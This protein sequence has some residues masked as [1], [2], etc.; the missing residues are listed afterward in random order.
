MNT[1]VTRKILL[2]ISGGLLGVCSIAMAQVEPVREYY[3][4]I[5]EQHIRDWSDAISPNANN[6]GTSEQVRSFTSL[7]FS[8]DA[9]VVYYDHWED[10]YEADIINPVQA[11]TEVWG[12]ANASNG[13]RPGCAV[14]SCDRIAAADLIVLDN[15]VQL[16]R[17]SASRYYD[18]RDY[19]ASTG[20]VVVSRHGYRL[21]EGSLL[22]GASEVFPLASWGTSFEAPV[23]ENISAHD[24]FSYSAVSII[25]SADSTTVNID[26]DGDGSADVTQVLDRG[27]SLFDGDLST[28][29]NGMLSGGTITATNPIQ[30]YLLTGDRDTTYAGRWYTLIPSE[31]WSDEYYTP[32]GS[33]DPDPSDDEQATFVTFYNPGASSITV[34]HETRSGGTVNSGTVS[35]PAGGQTDLRMPEDSGG[36]FYTVGNETFY[37]LATVDYDS[38]ATDWGFPLIPS[39]QLTTGVVVGLGWGQVNPAAPP[40]EN[41]SPV[42]VTAVADTTLFIDYDS[43]PTTGSLIDANGD[44]YDAQVA[45][46]EL[47][48]L[49]IRDTSDGDQ[50]QLRIYTLDGTLI[51]AAWGQDPATAS[52]AAP[53]LDMGTFVIPFPDIDVTKEGVLIFDVDGDGAMDPGDTIQYTILVINNG[54]SANEAVLEDTLD[55]NTTYVPNTVEIDGV[56]IADDALPDTAFPLDVDGTN[57]GYNLGVLDPLQVVTIVFQV[58]INN[59]LPPGVEGLV[60]HVRV[61]ASEEVVADTALSVLGDPGITISKVSDAAGPLSPGDVVT[62]TITVNNTSASAAT[63]IEV[64]DIVPSNATYVA[65]STEVLAPANQE[66]WRDEFDASSYSNNDGTQNWASDWIETDPNG[67]DV[68]GPGTQSGQVLTIF[69]FSPDCNG[70]QC[71]AITAD[72]SGGAVDITGMAFSRSADLT[73]AVT[74]TLS[75]THSYYGLYGGPHGSLELQVRDS[76]GSGWTTL[77]T[78][79]YGVTNSFDNFESYDISAHI[80]ATTEIRLLGSGNATG[81]KSFDDIQITGQFYDTFSNAAGA[82]NALLDGNPQNLVRPADGLDL[83]GGLSM[84]VTYEATVDGPPAPGNAQVINT[85]I[86]S[87]NEV[88]QPQYAVVAD[89]LHSGVVSGRVWV[90]AD[91]DGFEDIVEPGIG[92]V[93]VSLVDPVDGIIGNGND[94]VLYTQDTDANGEY[95]FYYLEAGDYY[96]DVDGADIPAGLT[97]SPGSTDPRPVFTLAAGEHR[98]DEDFGYRPVNP[99]TQVAIGD[100]VFADANGNG[101]QDDGEV[102]IANVTVQV[103]NAQTGAAGA[104]ATTDSMGRYLFTGLAPGQWQVRVTDTGGVLTGYTNTTGGETSDPV[105]LYAGETSL[106]ADFGYDIAALY[107]IT[108]RVW[109]DVDGDGT[110]DATE[111]GIAGTT[112]KLL[113]NG[114]NLIAEAATDENGEFSF[115]GLPNGDY[116]VVIVD[117]ADTLQGLNG[118]T[119]PAVLGTFDYTVSG[120]DVDETNFGYG[121]PASIS[122]HVF[123]DADGDAVFDLRESPI[124]SAEVVLWRDADGDGVFDSTVDTQIDTETT[125]ANGFYAFTG[126]APGQYFVSVDD[127]QA[128]L[129]S[130]SVTTSDEQTGGN[131]AGTQLDARL[132]IPNGGV[133]GVDFGYQD[134][135]L[136]DIS[137]NVWHDLDADGVDDGAGEPRLQGVTIGLLDASGNKVATVTT[138]ANGDYLFADVPAGSYTVAV[139]DTEGVLTDFLLTSG[140][141][142]IPVTV[143][144]SDITDIDFGYVKERGDAILGGTLWLD[145]DH[146]GVFQST[147]GRI[148]VATVELY[149]AGPDGVVG[150]GDDVLVASTVTDANGFYVFNDL[151]AGRYYT[152][153]AQTTLPAGL[154]LTTGSTDPGSVVPLSNGQKILNINYGYVSGSGSLIGDQ[155]WADADADGVQDPGEVGI[156]GVEIL[157]ALEAGGFSTTITTDAMGRWLVTGLAPGDYYAEVDP[158]TLPAGLETTPTNAG[159]T[160]QFTVVAGSDILSLDWGFEQTGGLLGNV[161]GTVYLDEDAN[162]SQDVSE[163]GIAAVTINLLDDNGN[164][165]ATTITDQIGDYSFTGVPAGTYDVAVT[166][167]NGV[168]IGLNQTTVDPAQFS[169]PA[170]GSQTGLDFGYAPSANAP[171]GT[172]GTLVFHDVDDSG[173]RIIDEPGMSR[174]TLHLWHDRNSNGAIEPGT[175][176]YLRSTITDANGEYR[177]NGLVAGDYLVQLVDQNGVTQGFTKT[178][179]PNPGEDNNSQVNPYFISIDFGST[180]G[181]GGGPVD[182]TADFGYHAGTGY[183]IAGTAFEDANNNATLDGESGVPNVTL[184][185]YRDLNNNGQLDPTD[186]QIGQMQAAADGTY[187]FDDLPAGR[188]LVVPKNAGTSVAGY[189]QTTQTGSA[190]IADVTIVNAPVTDVDFGYYDSGVTTLP[191]TLGYFKAFPVQQGVQ[192]EWTTLTET[193]NIG[194]VLH[195][196]SEGQVKAIAPLKP[197]KVHDSLAPTHYQMVVQTDATEFW[198]SDIDAKGRERRHGPFSLGQSFGYAEEVAMID[199]APIRA[200]HATFNGRD[201]MG[202]E[203]AQ[204][205]VAADGVYRV[206]YAD[207]LGQG[208]D[209]SGPVEALALTQNHVPVPLHVYAPDGDFGAGDWVQFVGEARKTLYSDHNVYRL[210]RDTASAKRMADNPFVAQTVANDARYLYRAK[211]AEN[212]AYGFASPLDDPWYERGLIWANGNGA[213]AQYDFTIDDRVADTPVTLDLS[214]WGVTQQAASPDHA[215]RVRFNGQVVADIT[216]D[217]SEAIQR[218]FDVTDHVAVTNTVTLEMTGAHGLDVDLV[219]VESVQLS[220]WREMRPIDQRLQATVASAQAGPSAEVLFSGSFEENPAFAGTGVAIDGFQSVQLFAYTSAPQTTRL[221]GIRTAPSAGGF[222]A[223]LPLLQTGG[224]VVIAEAGALLTPTITGVADAT[225]LFTGSPQYLMIAH[226]HFMD[227]LQPLVNFHSNNGMDVKVVDVTDI[228]GHYRGGLV[229]AAAIREYLQDMVPT[230]VQYVLLVGGDSYDYHDNL[231]TGS[232]SF[233]PTLYRQTA[234]VVMY[235]PSDAAIADIDGDLAPDVALGR[236]PVRTQDELELMVNK[237]LEYAGKTWGNSAVF[238]AGPF[239]QGLS[240]SDYSDSLASHLPISW[241]VDKAYM[242]IMS[243]D[244]A[245]NVLIDN[246][247][248]GV[249]LTTY[250]GHSAPTVWNFP[251]VLAGLGDITSLTNSGKPTMVMQFS[252]WNSYF[253]DPE[254]N[255]IAQRFLTHGDMGAAGVAGPTALTQTDSLRLWGNQV[256]PM[257]ASPG[258]PMGDALM[259]SLRSLANTHPDRVD[260]L[261]GVA[262]LG[263]PALVVHD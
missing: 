42:W 200:E 137:G 127:G 94:V 35:V 185:L 163:P 229:D 45:I 21:Q 222:V 221:S 242:D 162:A 192:V 110:F 51:T 209:L 256:M 255:T 202:Y 33:S 96:V 227:G 125:N 23:G 36:H 79:N 87:S 195:A 156:E 150:G 4:P 31:D 105:S 78:F 182:F 53:A 100:T 220:W 208:V 2:S 184:T 179:A 160:Y 177:F 180:R 80:S 207:L 188:Y 198:L 199:W 165:L 109:A 111:S 20:T 151:P 171:I 223:T 54:V 237:T 139:T 238:A 61:T 13:L 158:S 247:N 176:N 187:Q 164:I 129:S 219:N 132:G 243:S 63:G 40:A 130:F 241:M 144:S 49:Q 231:G 234:D 183:Y 224:D 213:S 149:D 70:S 201:P 215:I 71:M 112:V 253:V 1:K 43:D 252:C 240:F 233:V 58:T 138:D 204:L 155:V 235:G 249:G 174:V 175:D 170:G 77:D 251:D 57:S 257:L 135:A 39:N 81:A 72:Y 250:F 65:E 225:D 246:I 84:F 9:A 55:I 68:N 218:Q 64:L 97:I 124:P 136:P 206:T 120:S 7:V 41:S 228:Y 147:E 6:G 92:A 244:D 121:K 143:A 50:S 69:G 226:P 11:S 114:G 166:D 154:S 76:G 205:G 26:R 119:N 15:D 123:S 141:D 161:S 88:P 116:Q 82:S 107:R 59:P 172:L 133:T 98:S 193:A 263:D 248:Q 122:G 44:L 254:Q 56:P 12:D 260:L 197:S 10:G 37:A 24:M 152:N 73:G 173:D 52:P 230:G 190:G 28:Q 18:A 203:I 168:L 178:N 3:I 113:D 27:E 245:Q 101:V 153:P 95:A 167:A 14:A 134:S 86:V 217:G 258:V 99:T 194:F 75:F 140:L 74:A 19:I 89:P 8:S 131:A 186:A 210:S 261:L 115:S 47:E 214:L 104:I 239:S 67:D 38:T 60:N 146:D 181:P 211:Q 196:R 17:N 46:S 93:T 142:E 106:E 48:S 30:V 5:D 118:T 236:F 128:V 29:G 22:G 157:V 117:A 259:M 108:D 189:T 32:A 191:V 62:Y 102:G 148:P 262:L 91:G 34:T 169:L 212:N 25:A 16:P 83:P 159:L 232:M 145:A 90:D 66:T 126:L 103:V 85:A 216:A